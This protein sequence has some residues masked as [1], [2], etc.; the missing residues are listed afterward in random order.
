MPT[1]GVIVLVRHGE[2][3]WS[4]SGRH[5]SRTDLALTAAGRAQAQ[6]IASLVESRAISEVRTSPLT[7]ATETCALLG[8]GDIAVVDDD[9]REWD[10][11]DDE[12]I[13]TE[14][15]RTT[16]PGWTLWADG[17]RN[18]ETIDDVVRRVDR[19]IA[20][21]ADAIETGDVV[22]VGHGHCLRVLAARWLGVDPHL[23]RCLALDAA[24]VSELGFEREQRVIRGWNRL[25]T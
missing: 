24:S 3:E 12:G 19:V 2:T 20:H 1:R 25:T 13:T 9:L 11:G 5:T 17:P 7:R 6:R 8:L 14:E 18:G 22:L 23:G 15:I 16:R 10:Y 4:R 21:A